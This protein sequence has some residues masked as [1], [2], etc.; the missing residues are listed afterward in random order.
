MGR[1]GWSAVLV[2]A[3]ALGGPGSAGAAD[4]VR[5]L[6]YSDGSAQ[7]RPDGAGGRQRRPRW[8]PA[9]SRRSWRWARRSWCSA[10]ISAGRARRTRAASTTR[11]GTPATPR[12]CIRRPACGAPSP[13]CR[14]SSGR[15]SAGAPR[16]AGG[17]VPG[18]P[19]TQAT[20]VAVG[21]EIL[22]FGGLRGNRCPDSGQCGYGPLAFPLEAALYDPERDAWRVVAPIPVPMWVESTVV[23]GGRMVAYGREVRLF[24]DRAARPAVR[25]R[26]RP[27]L[28]PH[29]SPLV[30]PACGPAPGPPLQ[31]PVRGTTRR[32]V[33]GGPALRRIGRRPGGPGAADGGRVRPGEPNLDTGADPR[34]RELGCR[35]G[36]PRGVRGQRGARPS[37][38]RLPPAA[39]KAPRPLHDRLRTR[40]ER[41]VRRPPGGRPPRHPRR[42]PLGPG[43]RQDGPPPRTADPG[44]P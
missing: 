26:R 11:W 31:F 5:P 29:H 17:R 41:P 20:A 7:E 25:R 21:G 15:R 3:L 33:R 38:R 10:G 32:R 35:R 23:S 30:R 6:G 18:G 14:C 9:S 8:R 39:T 36:R 16:G 37:D 19:R 24:A 27:L 34:R 28:R 13:R 40:P 2:V 43:H 4:R 44:H 12:S 22:V 1:L 42:T